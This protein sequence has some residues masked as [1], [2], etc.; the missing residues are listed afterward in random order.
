MVAIKE[1]SKRFDTRTVLTNV[2]LMARPGEL[3]GI[4]GPSGS[5]KSTLL[6]CIVGFESFESGIIHVD[7]DARHA[8]ERFVGKSSVALH[9][10]V[11]FVSQGLGL[12]P[13]K[14]VASNITEGLIYGRRMARPVAM[15]IA[16]E[17]AVRL[18][19]EG[20]LRKYPT[21]L[22]GGQRQRV[23][24]ARAVALTPTYLLL[25]EITA[26]LDPI[27]AGE[28]CEIVSELRTGGTGIVI[29]SHHID[30][31]RNCADRVV[32][33][34]EGRI[35]EEGSAMEVLTTPRTPELKKFIE[36]VRRGW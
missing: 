31:V 18:R 3:V 4:I 16:Q 15:A 21:M 11:G 24:I 22:S 2:S 33:L 36:S 9:R 5:G 20:E 7:D 28:I 1:L 27:L 34:S 26:S 8:G 12:W 10:K 32:F 14:T 25:D 35:V 6:R 19:I 17:W 23:A 13:N 30:F 29:V